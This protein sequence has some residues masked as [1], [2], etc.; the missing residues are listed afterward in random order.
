VI[1]RRTPEL[2]TR[3]GLHGRM[4]LPHGMWV[5]LSALFEHVDSYEFAVG[6]TRDN[7]GVSA[8]FVWTHN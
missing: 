2:R 6:A 4:L 8:A 3:V 5:Q 1:E 7:G